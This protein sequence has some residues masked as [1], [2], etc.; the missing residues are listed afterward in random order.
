MLYPASSLKIAYQIEERSYILPKEILGRG[1][2]ILGRENDPRQYLA[3][4]W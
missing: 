3:K 4:S 1:K 2:E